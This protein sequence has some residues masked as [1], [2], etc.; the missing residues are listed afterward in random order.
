MPVPQRR[1]GIHFAQGSVT[2]SVLAVDRSSLELCIT[3]PCERSDAG[4]V[5]TELVGEHNLKGLPTYVTLSRSDYDTQFVDLPGVAEHE[6]R[7]ALPWRVTPP[8]VLGGDEIVT[9]GARLNNDREIGTDEPTLVRA[10]I[11][12]RQMLGELSTA[13]TGAGLDLRAVYPRETALITVAKQSVEDASLDESS[14]DSAPP[15]MTAFVARRSTGVTVARGDQLYLSRTVTLSLDEQTGLGE[16]QTQQLISECVRT[17]TNF[18]KRLSDTPLTQCL[19]GPDFEG[20]E[21]VRDTLSESLGV[22]CHRL[23]LPPHVAPVDERTAAAGNTPE[24]MLAIAAMLNVSLPPSASI[25]QPPVKDRSIT[26]PRI[27]TAATAAGLAVLA[28]ING[29]Q[30]WMAHNQASRLEALEAE[31]TDLQEQTGALQAE[32]ESIEAAEPSP[33]L[34]DR[35]DRLERQRNAYNRMIGAFEGVDTALLSGFAT[36]LTAIGEA[37]VDG[38]WL[39]RIEMNTDQVTLAGRTLKA[40]K[41]EQFARE[42]ERMPAFRGWSPDTV[43]INNRQEPADD[44]VVH[45]FTISG[46]DLFASAGQSGENGDINT[47]EEDDFSRLLGDINNNDE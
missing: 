9:T 34:V 36:P 6:L 15:I 1:A 7:D 4:R 3:R 38:V 24:G 10:T 19:I 2:L 20:L 32:L 42:L 43:D 27:L 33:A 8:G 47:V 13:V 21:T 35:R 40:F 46:P 14:A 25:Y 5:L 37:V 31:Q 45:D 26:S 18:N 16:T 17:A 11:M 28:G 30:A 41:A 23:T 44:L 22:D 12:S 39:R 29:V